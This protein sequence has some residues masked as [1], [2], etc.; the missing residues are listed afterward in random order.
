MSEIQ[1]TTFK[2]A[3][4]V[5]L[6]A[7][8]IEWDR[9]KSYEAITAV[10]YNAFTYLSKKP[11]PKN[12]E[13]TN[14]DF[15]LRWADPNSQMEQLY[16]TFVDLQEN[17]DQWDEALDGEIALRESEDSDIRTEIAEHSFKDD[18]WLLLGDSYAQGVAANLDGTNGDNWQDLLESALSLQHVYKYKAGSAGFVA[19]STSTSG[20]SST[21][22]TNTDYNDVMNYAYQY[23]NTQGD[24]DK[25]KYIVIQGGWN[26]SNVSDL[27]LV[28]AAVENCVNTLHTRYKNAKIF[29]VGTLCGSKEKTGNAAKTSVMQQYSNGCRRRNAGFAYTMN[30]PWLNEVASYDTVHPTSAMQRYVASFI[31][32]FV[33]TGNTRDYIGYVGSSADGPV[34]ISENHTIQYKM[35]N[36]EYTVGTDNLLADAVW[37]RSFVRRNYDIALPYTANDSALRIGIFRFY[38]D[39]RIRLVNSGESGFTPTTVNLT[40]S[41][42]EIPFH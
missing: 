32:T 38:L 19:K 1:T 41:L 15:W 33:L 13:I 3:R 24:V 10:Q 23:I 8:P 12:V 17:V 26:D 31:G 29:V 28:Q 36:H 7:D 6:F 21:V 39:G 5:P 14:T 22:P 16:E 11:V 20:S 30:L 25:I 42:M 4:Y 35:F 34:F 2:G 37:W 9:T 40:I 27:S 18:Y